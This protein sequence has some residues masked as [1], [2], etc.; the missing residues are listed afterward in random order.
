MD[1]WMGIW[2]V[3]V[4]FKEDNG[5]QIDGGSSKEGRVERSNAVVRL[6]QMAPFV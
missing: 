2:I 6:Y 5:E 3:F 1:N 4:R